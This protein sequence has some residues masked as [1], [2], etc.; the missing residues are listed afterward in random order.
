M[1]IIRKNEQSGSKCFL[2]KN[3]IAGADDGGERNAIV[4]PGE[5]LNTYYLIGKI[6]SGKKT[7]SGIVIAC[8]PCWEDYAGFALEDDY[9]IQMKS[10]EFL[11]K[12]MQGRFRDE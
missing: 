10:V 9:D 5:K 11:E 1:T 7:G 6:R 8:E 3:I 2:C 4:N 12:M